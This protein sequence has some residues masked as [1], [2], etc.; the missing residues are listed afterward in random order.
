M[1]NQMECQEIY[2]N[3]VDNCLLDDDD[4][5]HHHIEPDASDD[6]TTSTTRD[7]NIK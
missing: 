4:D 5:F 1:M 6:L 3:L 7:V 2:N